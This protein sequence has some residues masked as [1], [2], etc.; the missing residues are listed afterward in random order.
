LNSRLNE[1]Y[2]GISRGILK[3]SGDNV[4]GIYNQDID[5]NI[6]LIELGG[7]NNN[8]EEVLNTIDAFS[9]VLKE[10]IEE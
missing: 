10:F 6:M 4:E 1:I 8:M 2:P 9:I 7:I 5:E 3:K